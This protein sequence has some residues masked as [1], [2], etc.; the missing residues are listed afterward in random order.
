MPAE[1]SGLYR[2]W[3]LARE[4]L[5]MCT[6]GDILYVLHPFLHMMKLIILRSH[7]NCFYSTI[8]YKERP[9]INFFFFKK[10]FFKTVG[11]YCSNILGHL[12]CYVW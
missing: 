12:C 6:V 3:E 1:V 10:T 2:M 5:T 11:F 9:Q 7:Q 8:T 4:S